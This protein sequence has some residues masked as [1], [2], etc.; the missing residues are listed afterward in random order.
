MTKD[1]IIAKLLE[2]RAELEAAGAEHVSLFGSV[3]RGTDTPASDLDI[4]VT[5]SEPVVQSGFGYYSA[6]E[7]LTEKISAITGFENVDVVAEPLRRAAVRARIE[8]DRALAF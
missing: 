3:A 5:L 2:H 8:K 1:E 6:L 4:L 7:V